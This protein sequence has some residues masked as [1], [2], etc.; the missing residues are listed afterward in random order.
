MD[1][2][3]LQVRNL[4]GVVVDDAEGAHAGGG[5]V[6]QDGR[7]ESPGPDHQHPGVLEPPLRLQAELG[8]Q[9]VPRVADHLLGG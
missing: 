4:D 1:H 3:A 5:Q 8:D 6:L 2:L 7:A 9:Q